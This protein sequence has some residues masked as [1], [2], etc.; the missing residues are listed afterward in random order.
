MVIV[1]TLCI[2]Q[3]VPSTDILPTAH[4]TVDGLTGDWGYIPPIYTDSEKSMYA[5]MDD[6]DVAFKIEYVQLNPGTETYFVEI[7][8]NTDEVADY[9]IKINHDTAVLQKVDTGETVAVEGHARIIVE[10]K[11]PAKICGNTFFVTSWIHNTAFDTVTAHFP[12]VRSFRPDPVAITQLTENEWKEDFEALY[13]LV[14]CNYPYIWLKE[15]THKYNWLNL[16]DEYMERLSTMKTNEE[17]FAL[18]SEAVKTLQND[19]THLLSSE[20][21]AQTK[22][23][24]DNPRWYPWNTILT[25]EIV[26]TNGYWSEYQTT[27]CPEVFF[28]YF[29]GEYIAVGGIGNW[30]EKYT[31]HTGATVTAVNGIPVDEAVASLAQKTFLW[32]NPDKKVL[33]VD[34]LDPVLFGENS[35]FTIESPDGI[36]KTHI[37]CV[38][39]EPYKELHTTLYGAADIEFKTFNGAAYMRV[40]SFGGGFDKIYRDKQKFLEFYEIIKEYDTLIIDIRGNMG[41]SPSY[42]MDNIVGPL[43]REDVCAAF[44]V[45]FRHGVYTTWLWG[46]EGVEPVGGVDLPPEVKDFVPL[47]TYEIPVTKSGPGFDGDIYILIDRWVM[48]AADRFAAFAK[49]TGFATVVGTPTG[50]DG[51]SLTPL[52]FVLPNSRL[53]VRMASSMGVTP[54]GIPTEETRTAPDVYVEPETWGADVGL[55]YYV[56]DEMNTEVIQ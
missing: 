17:F 50:G 20:Y 36:I 52:Y 22:D 29:K 5:V 11:I 34:F 12:W 27:L 56:L 47:M 19:H 15:K 13:Y 16:K 33:F 21:V 41:G 48:S 38:S 53:V 18:M 14:M 25:D 7:D 26:D 2:T 31:L 28:S 39:K 10:V 23:I 6:K 49:T 45:T 42:W 9:C 3:K 24:Y 8:T 1:V 44:H 35:L 40:P 30:K 37:E 4:I 55:V 51:V 54:D 32:Y 43:L 46:T